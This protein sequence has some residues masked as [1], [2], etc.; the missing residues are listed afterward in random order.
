VK[1]EN[2][3]L[4]SPAWQSLKALDKALFVEMKHRCRP[5]NNGYLGFSVRDAAELLSC[6]PETASRAFERLEDRGLIRLM[7]ESNWQMRRAREWQLTTDKYNDK[8]P[9]NDW[10]KWAPEN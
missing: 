10:K 6:K 3:L 5:A 1:L 2:E 7:R 9:T 4:E 8:Q